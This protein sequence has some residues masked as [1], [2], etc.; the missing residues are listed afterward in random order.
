MVEA[1]VTG[2]FKTLL[3]IAG[4]FVLLRFI[5]R[6]MVAKRNLDEERQLNERQ[7]KTEKERQEKIRNFG[8]TTIIG[9]SSSNKKSSRDS[10]NVV[11]V[12][13]EEIE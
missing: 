5:G 9:N 10:G 8:R 7:R 11:D 3:I 13:F 6:L 2:I 4:A 12:D 1:S